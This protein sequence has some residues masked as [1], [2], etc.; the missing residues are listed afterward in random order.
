[1]E[2]ETPDGKEILV[3][4]IAKPEDV[5]EVAAFAAEHFFNESPIRELGMFDDQSDE[6]GRFY[7]RQGRLQKCFAHPTSIVVREKSTGQVV[8]FTA[9]IL[10]EREHQSTPVNLNLN[11]NRSPGWLNRALAA[12]LNR[13]VDLYSRYGT[14]RILHFW[15][16]AVRKDYRG[17]GVSSSAS[18]TALATQIIRDSK[19]GAF[20]AVAFSHYAG[21][22]HWN[23]DAIRT[24]DFAAFELPDGSRPLAGVDLGVHR[25]ARLFA[26]RAPS[27][28][29]VV[30][31]NIPKSS[32]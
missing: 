29:E 15:F 17:K 14:D 20:K 2:E 24:I 26:A 23:W 3:Y 4:H 19:A 1:M 13:G 30:T 18:H 8:G 7:W 16:G 32:L 5:E 25:T 11:N 22:K 27:F 10:E 6:A 31:T 28:E 9:A 12:E 21:E